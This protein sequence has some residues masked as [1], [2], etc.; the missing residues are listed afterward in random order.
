MLARKSMTARS[1]HIRWRR[2]FFRALNEAYFVI[3]NTRRPTVR[4]R[5]RLTAS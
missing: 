4:D 2:V 3:R 5:S 1:V